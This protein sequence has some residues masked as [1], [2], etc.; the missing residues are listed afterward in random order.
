MIAG[1]VIVKRSIADD[2]VIAHLDHLGDLLGKLEEDP[3]IDI[4]HQSWR[5]STK[6]QIQVHRLVVQTS[7]FEIDT[8]RSEPTAVEQLQTASGSLQSM[9]QPPTDTLVIVV[10]TRITSPIATSMSLLFKVV[11]ISEKNESV[12]RGLEH[13]G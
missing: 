9:T 7:S 6:L 5:C 3:I 12:S 13:R 8:L 10:D 4:E 1:Y 2:Y 11:A